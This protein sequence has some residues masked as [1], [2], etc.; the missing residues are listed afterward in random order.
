L[1]SKELLGTIDREQPKLVICGHIHAGHGRFEYN[2]IPIYNVSVVDEQ[3]RLV[4]SPTVISFPDLS[5]GLAIQP[6]AS[7]ETNL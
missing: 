2:G 1:G 4:H 6:A 5:A 3:Y 7:V